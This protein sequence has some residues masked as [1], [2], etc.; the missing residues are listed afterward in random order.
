MPCLLDLDTFDIKGFYCTDAIKRL[1]YAYHTVHCT[2]YRTSKKRL[3]S[4]TVDPSCIYIEHVISLVFY[5]VNTVTYPV[6]LKTQYIHVVIST[7][8]CN[9]NSKFLP[10]HTNPYHTNPIH[11]NPIQ[12]QTPGFNLN[13]FYIYPISN[14]K[15]KIRLQTKFD[16]HSIMNPHILTP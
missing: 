8:S 5:I 2:S 11:T 13:L 14:P 4:S 15:I 6:Y 3:N 1:Q 10:F 12:N 7:M 16:L 9:S